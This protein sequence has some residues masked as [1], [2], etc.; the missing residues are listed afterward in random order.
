MCVF[1]LW[2]YQLVHSVPKLALA[3]QTFNKPPVLVEMEIRLMHVLTVLAAS[4]TC[5]PFPPAAGIHRCCVVCA[6]RPNKHCI[7]LNSNKN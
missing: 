1:V 7:A 6:L 3:N 4:D 2:S 5:S